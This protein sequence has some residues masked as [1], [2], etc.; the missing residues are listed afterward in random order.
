M[1]L[2]NADIRRHSLCLV[3]PLCPVYRALC[4]H[5]PS[6]SERSGRP[7]VEADEGM[8]FD[9]A[10]PATPADEQ[11][12][13]KFR[14]LDSNQNNRLQRTV[15]CQLPHAGPWLRLVT[16]V[17]VQSCLSSDHDTGPSGT[18]AS[19]NLAWTQAAHMIADA[20]PSILR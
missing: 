13:G 16:K 4:A 2:V 9:R 7:D 1:S 8:I 20:Q 10:P 12:K 6:G 3:A 17:V 11:D 5:P 14:R 18:P 15:G 19:A